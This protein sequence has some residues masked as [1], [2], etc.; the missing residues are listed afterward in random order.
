M[1]RVIAHTEPSDQILRDLLAQFLQSGIGGV[2]C[3]APLQC[4]DTL[5]SDRP[6]RVKVRFADAQRDNIVHLRNDIKKLADPGR[7]QP[8]SFLSEGHPLI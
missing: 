3:L 7:F 6:G 5:V 4:I 8:D 1:D 2:E